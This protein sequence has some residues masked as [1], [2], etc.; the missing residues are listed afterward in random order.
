MKSNRCP[1]RPMLP[2]RWPITAMAPNRLSEAR[3]SPAVTCGTEESGAIRRPILVGLAVEVNS[4][5]DR[6]IRCFAAAT[7]GLP[8]AAQPRFQAI[9][10]A[11]L[12]SSGVNRLRAD[13]QIWRDADDWSPGLHHMQH[14]APEDWRIAAPVHE[15]SLGVAC[16][17]FRL[18]DSGDLGA[19]LLWA[20]RSRCASPRRV[21]WTRRCRARTRAVRARAG[22]TT[23]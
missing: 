3:P 17:G 20:G 21:G 15:P 19:A 8:R 16:P 23:S 10:D 1:A 6:A 13:P 2:Q 4:A 9:V 7:S 18:R 11:V 14:L 22:V 5:S 12:T